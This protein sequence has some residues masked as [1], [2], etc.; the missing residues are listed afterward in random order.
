MK[1]KA[2]AQGRA[3][4]AGEV[5]S[6]A[7]P[8]KNPA[9]PLPRGGR[10]V[11]LTIL[12]PLGTDIDYS[13]FL[14]GNGIDNLDDILPVPGGIVYVVGT[15]RSTT[16]NVF[17]AAQ[18]ID[19]DFIPGPNGT[20]K[21]DMF[22]A[23]FDTS[24]AGPASLIYS[25][26]LGGNGFEG[27]YALA[28]DPVGRVMVL[29]ETDATNFGPPGTG[30]RQALTT[31]G[32]NGGILLVESPSHSTA[33]FT[34]LVTNSFGDRY[35]AGGSGLGFAI[36]NPAQPLFGGGNFDAVV[37]RDCECDSVPLGA[38]SGRQ[39]VSGNDWTFDYEVTPSE[40]VALHD[41]RL[42]PRYMAKK[43]SVPYF[44]LTTP[45][46]TFQ[47]LALT[48]TAS[49]GAGSTSL[50]S[51]NIV[52]PVGEEG[53]PPP[54][55]KYQPLVVEATYAVKDVSPQGKSCLRMRQRYEFF[56]PISEAD[57]E[58]ATLA[59]EPS[60]VVPG[61]LGVIP[62]LLGHGLPCGRLKPLL[63]YDYCPAEREATFEV[64]VASRFHFRADGDLQSGHLL[65][66]D[67]DTL[68][69][70]L[71]S[72]P[73]SPITTPLGNPLNAEI[74]QQPVR[75]G[76]RVPGT[77]DNFHQKGRVGSG[78]K[79]TEPSARSPGCEECV[80][81]HW[82]WGTHLGFPPA[83]V[84]GGP[85]IPRGSTQTIDWGVVRFRAGEENPSADFRS[86]VDGE[87]ILNADSVFWYGAKSSAG[88][89]R[90]LGH[91]L[92]FSP[93]KAAH[94]SNGS[95]AVLY[96]D[97]A[98]AG[99]TTFAPVPATGVG[100][101]PLGYFAFQDPAVDIRAEGFTGTGPIIVAFGVAE[102]NDPDLFSRLRIFHR[103]GTTQVDRTVLTGEFA[104]NFDGRTIYARVSSL[105]PFVL[106]LGPVSGS[107]NRPPLALCQ[108]VDRDADGVCMASV[109]PF[110]VDG[111]SSDP[112]GDFLIRTLSPASPFGLGDHGVSLGV[113]DP[114]GA[115]ATCQARVRVTDRTPPSIAC[116]GPIVVGTDPGR[117]SAGPNIAAPMVEDNCGATLES[118]RSDGEN[119]AARF[120]LG[121]TQIDWQAK[122]GSG[123]SSSCG[124]QVTVEDREPPT[125]GNLRADRAEIWPPSHKMVNVTVGYDVLD[126]CVAH[127]CALSVTS[128]EPQNGLGDG[129]TSPDWRIVDDHHVELRAERSGNGAGR[130]YTI[131]LTCTD[132]AG[133]ASSLSTT[134]N[135][136][137]SR[138]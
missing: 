49:G 122:D 95:W 23:R 46:G 63:E 47:H 110:D 28:L 128:N 51:L 88:S 94:A 134:V 41:V 123:L 104:P 67:N 87:P 9:Q 107:V 70:I 135:V 25:T 54:V 48:S 20:N 127:V 119:L 34:Q 133:L 97:D 26:Y 129:D 100:T 96:P 89:D 5:F 86:L 14:G 131:G 60:Q 115:S 38:P 102:V 138:K 7:Y 3:F 113:F 8:V 10:D 39:R 57:A 105:S 103:E 6:S 65:A 93:K 52:M 43:I 36:V 27:A 90:F 98:E 136:P 55:G 33:F 4:I 30:R 79:V 40:G 61:I 18:P 37:M 80:H 78:E 74:A 117:C 45:A 125:I 99:L 76:V 16:F 121:T 82:R 11:F 29:S 81:M 71:S 112:D 50:I 106:A 19:P 114:T 12:N 101:L 118:T 111:G 64:N 85:L 66:R 116:S 72:L 109:E 2:D 68:S 73:F 1:I 77:V 31:H 69:E 84:P 120:L 91:G 44:D 42:G 132:R 124:Q 22:L 75:L 32:P 17:N 56:K 62:D 24:K 13:T 108:D 58:D 15:T 126:N 53:A 92:F 130:V 83:T 137:K 21:T 59:C 35:W